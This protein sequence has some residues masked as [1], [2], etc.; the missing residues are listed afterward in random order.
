LLSLLVSLLT[1]CRILGFFISFALVLFGPEGAAVKVIFVGCVSSFVVFLVWAVSVCYS[2]TEPYQYVAQ[3]AASGVRMAACTVRKGTLDMAK[4]VRK[5]SAGMVS[6]TVGR[7][8]TLT[9]P[10]NSHQRESLSQEKL[11]QYAPELSSE[12]QEQVTD[13]KPSGLV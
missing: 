3:K 8:P 13:A 12:P 7:W 6:V 9:S 2:E 5:G 10:G 1:L 11:P 4:T